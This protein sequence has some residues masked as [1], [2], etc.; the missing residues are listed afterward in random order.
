MIFSPMR[1]HQNAVDLINADDLFPVSDGLEHG[2]D[3]D[4]PEPA[5]DAFA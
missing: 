2:G 1:L 5:Q 4:V 3:A